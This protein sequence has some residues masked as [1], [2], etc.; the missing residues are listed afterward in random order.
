MLRKSRT[1]LV[2]SEYFIWV[3]A[4]LIVWRLAFVEV[5]ALYPDWDE[6]RART[7]GLLIYGTCIVAWILCFASFRSPSFGWLRLWFKV[8]ICLAILECVTRNIFYKEQNEIINSLLRLI[9]R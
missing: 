1:I 4:T 2:G 7:L 6:A 3:A 8:G 5:N 9:H